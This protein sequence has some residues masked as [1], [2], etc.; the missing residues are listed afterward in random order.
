MFLYSQEVLH[1]IEGNLREQELG[2]RTRDEAEKPQWSTRIKRLRQE[3][4]SP[5]IWK[6]ATENEDTFVSHGVGQ[7]GEF[8]L[9]LTPVCGADDNEVLNVILRMLKSRTLEESSI[10]LLAELVLGYVH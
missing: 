8:S 9:R 2:K 6:R 10:V 5:V 3:I 4:E 7:Q 1:S